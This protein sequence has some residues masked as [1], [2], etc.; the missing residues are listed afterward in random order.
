M[1]Q[2]LATFSMAMLSIDNATSVAWF[3]Q[4]GS[5]HV[6]SKIW[7]LDEEEQRS[8]GTHAPALTMPTAKAASGCLLP[9][10]NALT[11]R[12]FRSRVIAGRRMVAARF[13]AIEWWSFRR[14]IGG[15]RRQYFFGSF[16]RATVINDVVIS[17]IQQFIV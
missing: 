1:V 9:I 2:A 11:V 17:A 16:S 8:G 13:I 15:R 14:T 12:L 6:V 3:R 5:W 4:N 7:H 10:L